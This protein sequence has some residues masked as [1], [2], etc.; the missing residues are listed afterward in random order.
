MSIDWKFG[1]VTHK[2]GDPYDCPSWIFLGGYHMVILFVSE[3]NKWQEP[4]IR[5]ATASGPD[6]L[7]RHDSTGEKKRATSIKIK[8]KVREKDPQKLQH[9]TINRHLKNNL[10]YIQW[11]KNDS[12]G[13]SE[14]FKAPADCPK[15]KPNQKF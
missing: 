6:D 10:E 7:S 8:I 15:V 2:W 3:E 11:K 5:Y 12:Q 1:D 14:I 13:D 4:L 9:C